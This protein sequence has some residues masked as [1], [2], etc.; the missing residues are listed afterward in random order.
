MIWAMKVTQHN[1]TT[2]RLGKTNLISY[3]SEFTSCLIVVLY[4]H[5]R[6]NGCIFIFYHHIHIHI[7]IPAEELLIY[8]INDLT[9][10]CCKISKGNPWEQ[11]K[12]YSP[13]LAPSDILHNFY[14]CFRNKYQIIPNT[15][16]L[17]TTY[18]NLSNDVYSKKG[19]APTENALNRSQAESR[20]QAESKSLQ[21]NWKKFCRCWNMGCKSCK[22]TKNLCPNT[23]HF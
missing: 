1:L 11:L 16:W 5:N 15:I 19:R 10:N 9:L 6:C 2:T 13:K 18:R 21:Q 12:W 3:F 4:V 8:S 22:E 17:K 14:L 7:H 20:P 23:K